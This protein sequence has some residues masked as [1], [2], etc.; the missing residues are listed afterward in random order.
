MQQTTQQPAIP[1]GYMQDAKG[2]LVPVSLVKPID[3]AR[4]GIV[5]ELAAKAQALSESLSKFKRSAFGDANAFVSMSADE[6]GVKLGGD[7][8]NVTLHSFDGKFKI[9]IAKADNIT[10]DERLQAAK[11][12]IDECIN[13]WSRGSRPEIQA[14]VQQ[15][16]ETDKEGT[17]N[18]GRVLALRRLDIKDEKWQSAMTAIGE[19]VQ[20]VGTKSY[21]R[22][23][24][25]IDGSD[26]YRAISL[27]LAT[28]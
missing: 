22:F 11:A 6:Y 8:G 19:S 28:V 2:H 23:Y 9:Q 17:L 24:E 14:L 13:E 16:F 12:L 25:R 26:E 10:F 27:D 7:K 18:T 15:A 1:E 21:L 3:L 4:D 5:R 20:I